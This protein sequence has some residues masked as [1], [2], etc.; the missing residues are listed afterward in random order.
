MS[1]SKSRQSSRQSANKTETKAGKT[2]E[3]ASSGVISKTETKAGK[4]DESASSGATS[5][6]ETEA[7]KTDE[8]AS[9]GAT[10]K[11]ETKAGKTDESASSGATS[12]TETKAG[13]T[14]EN[15]SSGATKRTAKAEHTANDKTLPASTSTTSTLTRP[16]GVSNKPL[17]KDAAKYARRLAERQQRLLAQRRAKR[18]KILA[19]ITAILLIAIAGG[20]TS[21]FIYQSQHPS[22]QSASSA[23]AYQEAVFDSNYPP[24]DNV[25]C[26]QLEQSIE[27]I[28]AHISIYIDGQLSPLPQ[29][30]GI[31]QNANSGQP[32]CF[33]WLHTHDSTGIIHI[34][35]PVNETF[36]L[37]EFLDE[38]NQQF[39]G[40]GFP[41]QLLLNSGW[42][43]WINGKPYH[44]SLTSIPLGRHD[45]ITVAYNSPKAQ[46]DT[47]YAW[48]GL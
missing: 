30:I 10:S 23:G 19:I 24:V 48:N 4:T 13:K 11:M 28:H 17:T 38:W 43:M 9:S 16:A 22:D 45:L 46:P 1:K 18:N 25:Y 36:T 37:G 26:D 15:V 20:L 42:T 27:H 35:A 31:P 47:K 12:K 39:S 8:N 3:S 32:T 2:D 29:Y 40:L 7:G 21:Y 14:D 34:E 41:T 33:Y 44:N 6:T 5:K